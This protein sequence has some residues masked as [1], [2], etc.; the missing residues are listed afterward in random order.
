MRSRR[1]PRTPARRYAEPSG[2]IALVKGL[3]GRMH[4]YEPQALLSISS[5]WPEALDE[6]R[7]RALLQQLTPQQML[8]TLVGAPLEQPQIEPWYSTPYELAPL[9]A[10]LLDEWG[11]APAHE[12][13]RLPTPNPYVPDDLT[14]LE[15]PHVGSGAED[16]AGDAADGDADAARRARQAER[17]PVRLTSDADEAADGVRVWHLDAGS[18]A[19]PRASVLLLLRTPAVDSSGLPEPARAAVLSQLAMDLLSDELAT[20]LAPCGLAGLGWSVGAH[21]GGLLIQASGYSQRVPRLSTDLARALAAFRPSTERFEVIR[22][23][24]VRTLRNRRQ[25]R[26]LWHA[27][28]AVSQALIEPR[29]HHA[30]ALAFASSEA[31]TVDAVRDWLR[32]ALEA[33]FL[34]MLVHGNLL[35]S[36]ARDLGAEWRALLAGSTP[37]PADCAPL[38][39]ARLLPPRQPLELHGVASNPDESNSAIEVFFQVGEPCL[40]DEALLL[41]LSQVASKDAF[42]VLRTQRQ[43]GY[44]VQCGVRSVARSRGLAVLIQSAVRPPPELEAEIESWVRSFREDVLRPLTP[45]VFEQYKAAVAALLVEPPKTLN[46]EASMIWPEIVEA[47]HDWTH[48]SRLAAAVRQLQLAD[49]VG[50]FDERIAPDGALRRK[51]VSCWASQGDAAAAAEAGPV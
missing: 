29:T 49:V 13:L 28:Y 5:D 7:L 10:S 33:N 30:A 46:Q 17:A 19:R 24:L 6:P 50:F 26:P 34:E 42:N 12:E 25:E 39:K 47:T 18:F 48:D 2:P 14:M 9:P 37:L 38:P 43:L 27:Q 11:A 44:V 15:Q 3:A 51:V 40:R 20:A 41:T 35:P 4:L 23:I 45:A 36:Q 31:C 8:L 21:Q 1:V 22:E 32:E 16:A